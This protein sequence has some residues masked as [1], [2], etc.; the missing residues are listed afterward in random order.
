MRLQLLVHAAAPALLRPRPRRRRGHLRL[1]PD[2]LPRPPAAR[3]PGHRA[4]VRL[5]RAAPRT[6]PRSPL[7][8]ALQRPPRPRLLR[9]PPLRS[10]APH[11]PDAPG[12]VLA[13]AHD[14]AHPRL[15][16]GVGDRAARPQ[17][18][19]GDGAGVVLRGLAVRAPRV[20]RR[21]LLL[22]LRQPPPRP[23]QPPPPAR[24][25]PALPLPPVPLRPRPLR[26]PP[27][28][29]PPRP[30][31]PPPPTRHRPRPRRPARVLLAD[32]PEPLRP[33]RPG[34]RLRAL[35][36]GRHRR[37]RQL[38]R[39]ALGARPPLRA[40]HPPRLPRALR[41][42]PRPLRARLAPRPAPRPARP[43]GRLLDA[44]PRAALDAHDGCGCEGVDGD[45]HW[46]EPHDAD[47]VRGRGA[48]GWGVLDGEFW[49]LGDWL[50]WWGDECFCFGLCGVLFF[51]ACSI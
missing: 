24:P 14:D 34:D 35:L 17:L 10:P 11:R 45:E 48:D 51:Y 43:D 31:P 39:P 18:R 9:P 5:R 28:P 3:Q 8:G 12:A 13:G 1:L 49:V 47:A 7:R 42:H 30:R 36:R 2:G 15:G 32:A 37:P 33:L 23:P 22:R 21:G 40:H 20:Q 19:R 41:P 27:P 16:A 4:A 44:P 26:P 38:L 29:P 46:A 25:A 50:V 6:H